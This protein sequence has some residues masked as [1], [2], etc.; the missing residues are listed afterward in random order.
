MKYEWHVLRHY[1]WELQQNDDVTLVNDNFSR[2]W[3]RRNNDV[4]LVNNKFTWDWVSQNDD[5][6]LVNDNFTGDW[7]FL[8]QRRRPR[9]CLRLFFVLQEQIKQ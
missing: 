6:T 1:S 8:N 3:V 7:K 2:D 4:S 5:A 9:H